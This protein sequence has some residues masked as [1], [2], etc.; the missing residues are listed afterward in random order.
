MK[1]TASLKSLLIAATLLGMTSHG[2]AE[3]ISLPHAFESG[4][5]AKAAEV[6]ANFTTL[7]DESNR[8]NQRITELEASVAETLAATEQMVC[9]SSYLVIRQTEELK[10]Q[11]ETEHKTY[12]TLKEIFAEGWKMISVGGTGDAN[13]SLFLF[14]R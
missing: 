8:Q 4:T 11:T 3:A 5:T 6:N 2:N 14:H 10:C 13:R 7:M 1:S 9:E 12:Y